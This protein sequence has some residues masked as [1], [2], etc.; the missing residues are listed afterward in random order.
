MNMCT[1][2]RPW[3]PFHETHLILCFPAHENHVWRRHVHHAR[4]CTSASCLLLNFCAP[5]QHWCVPCTMHITRI[6]N[7]IYP[8]TGNLIH[9][10]G[11]LPLLH[12]R[13]N[14][15]T[16]NKLK[17]WT[18]SKILLSDLFIDVQANIEEIGRSIRGLSCVLLDPAQ[19]SF[20]SSYVRSGGGGV[21]LIA[22]RA[23]WYVQV[24]VWINTTKLYKKR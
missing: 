21:D 20:Y 14:L 18:L 6:V 11:K 2:I 5:Y 16:F 15:D 19:A 9:D 22:G 1:L 12:D 3:W 24:L 10:T 7:H 4:S 23:I 17:I 13:V 8:D